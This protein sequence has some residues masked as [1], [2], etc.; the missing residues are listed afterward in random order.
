M[1][2]RKTVTDPDLQGATDALKRAAARAKELAA[3]MGTPCYVMRDGHIVD[4][5]TGK[6]AILFRNSSAA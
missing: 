4:A 2:S 1:N 6:E 3:R 5:I